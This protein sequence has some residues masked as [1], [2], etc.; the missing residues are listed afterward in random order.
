[1]IAFIAAFA[2]GMLVLFCGGG[3]LFAFLAAIF[4]FW[5]GAKK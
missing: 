5:L 1:M 3:L 2:V 4:V